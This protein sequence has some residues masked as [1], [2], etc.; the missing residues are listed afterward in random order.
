MVA[1][2]ALV[3][4]IVLAAVFAVAGA[5]KLADRRGTR[6]AVTDFGAPEGLAGLLAIVLPLA[7]LTVACLLVFPATAVAGAIGALA[8]LL[9]FSAAIT[10]NL[11]HGRAP[12]CHCFGSCALRRRAGGPSG[13]NGTLAALAL[14]ALVGSLMDPSW[15]ASTGSTT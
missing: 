4:R 10:L 12:E 11:A 8:L 1:A 15:S 2:L 7:E 9:I 14:V 3:A 5:A 6:Q 13:R